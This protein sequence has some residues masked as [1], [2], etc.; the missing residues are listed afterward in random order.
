MRYYCGEERHLAGGFGRFFLADTEK[1]LSKLKKSYKNSIQL[2]YL[3]PPFGTGDTFSMKLGKGQRAVK[4]PLYQDQM[5]RDEYLQ[6]MRSILKACHEM[7][8]PSGSLYLHID[9]RMHAHLKLLLDDIFSED[10]FMNEIIWSYKSGGRSTRYF[11]RKHDVILFYRKS[12]KVYFD[13]RAVGKPRG[14]ERR[15]HMKRFVDEDGRVGF[16]IRSNGK[17]YKYYEDSLIFPTDVW[18]DIEHL[19]QKDKERLGYATQKPEALLQRIILSSSKEGDTV[20]D[21]F[22]GSGTTAAVASKLNRRFVAVDASPVSLYTIRKRLLSLGSLIDLSGTASTELTLSYPKDMCEAEL[23][24]E[25][26]KRGAHRFASV[27]SLNLNG[28]GSPPVYAA[29]GTVK[30]NCFYPVETNCH[31]RL[32]IK[33]QLPRDGEAVIHLVDSYG[34]QLF[35][36]VD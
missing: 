1:S 5:P 29:I 4:I 32:P 9:Y 34:H 18:D 30:G 15:N 21:L 28:A 36:G 31:P 2:I 19:Q 35:W 17:L 16:S 11:P 13:I 25:I 22:S 8:A 26:I 7:L 14:A 6:W 27:K 10:N 3:D 20:M 24:F 12:R 33:L 23:D